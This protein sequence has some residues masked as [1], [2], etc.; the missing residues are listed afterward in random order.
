LTTRATDNQ[1]AVGTSA[2]VS[3]TVTG[4]SGCTAPQYVENG[5]YVAGSRV[6]NVGSQY[7]CKPYPF[8]GWCNGAAWAYAPGTG[9]YWQDAWILIGSCS[10][11]AAQPRED[12]SFNVESELVVSPNPGANG[13]PQSLILTFAHDAG[14]V[15][16][17][18]I[19]MSGR[20]IVNENH[21]QVKRS[22][23][24]EVPALTTGLYVIRVQ[25]AERTMTTKYMVE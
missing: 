14:N 19:N 16:V 22:L 3:V 20:S 21:E 23:S 4:G 10:A 5:G 1:G 18:L 15:R 11:R 25:N 2:I 12:Q 13:R 24:F 17:T 8:T 6:Q 7:E 9:T